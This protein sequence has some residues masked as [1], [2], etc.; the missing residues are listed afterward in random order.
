VRRRG[1]LAL[2]ELVRTRDDQRRALKR[3]ERI[4]AKADATI[5]RTMQRTIQ[6]LERE[7]LEYTLRKNKRRL[8]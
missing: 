6:T 3:I 4:C 8:R 5:L 2:E 1:W 7:K